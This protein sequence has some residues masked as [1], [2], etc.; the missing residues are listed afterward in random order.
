VRQAP[1]TVQSAIQQHQLM[2]AANGGRL[3]PE[4]QLTL[5]DHHLMMRGLVHG[6]LLSLVVWAAIGYVVF[7]LR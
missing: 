1:S 3:T 7:T 6:V 5:D 2:S 4:A